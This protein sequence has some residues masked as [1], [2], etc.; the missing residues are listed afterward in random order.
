[1]AGPTR[2]PTLSRAR[3]PPSGDEEAT[4]TLRLGEMDNTPCLSVA[5]CH[6][7][8]SRLAEKENRSNPGGKANSDVYLKTRE[9]VGIFARFKD[10]KTVTQVDVISSALLGKGERGGVTAFER[11]QLATLCCDTA[12]EA[13]TLIP[14]LEGKLDDETLQGVLDDMS[15]LRDFN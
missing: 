7:L 9:Y 4:S 6:E 2:P 8:L 10:S 3:P 11:A 15:K 12:E 14:S 5:E 13:R 1:M